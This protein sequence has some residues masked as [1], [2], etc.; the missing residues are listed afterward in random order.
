MQ[1]VLRIAGHMMTPQSHDQRHEFPFSLGYLGSWH[2]NALAGKFILSKSAIGRV[3]SSSAQIQ[4]YVSRELPL[5][6]N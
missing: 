4:G 6:F 1:L 5:H 2:K 3:F